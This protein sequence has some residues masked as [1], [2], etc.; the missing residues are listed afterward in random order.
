MGRS[1]QMHCSRE[2]DARPPAFPARAA[3]GSQRRAAVESEE[4]AGARGVSRVED[5]H[6]LQL[7]PGFA[8][9][10]RIGH[11][12]ATRQLGFASGASGHLESL[13]PGTRPSGV[14]E[15]WAAR[16]PPGLA[17]R[18]ERGRPCPGQPLPQ[19]PGLGQLL[20][21]EQGPPPR[22]A[23]A[24]SGQGSEASGDDLG[25]RS[26]LGGLNWS[27]G[28]ALPR[29][30]GRG[31][32]PGL[33]PGPA[34]V[35]TADSIP[36]QQG[37]PRTSR[38]GADRPRGRVT[39]PWNLAGPVGASGPKIRGAALSGCGSAWFP[40][41]SCLRAVFRT[42]GPSRKWAQEAESMQAR[43]ACGAWKF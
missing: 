19:P 32:G 2:P 21:L 28:E 27:Q 13:S 39:A 4:R 25:D 5:L 35:P 20:W 22:A 38:I 18:P 30:E 17:R 1:G 16:T 12:R 33:S 8:G 6:G 36:G 34:L 7:A 14:R 37:A 41:S 42:G 40:G 24:D 3:P 31:S 11:E 43:L 23:C 10:Q 26:D 15:Q 29:T 9:P